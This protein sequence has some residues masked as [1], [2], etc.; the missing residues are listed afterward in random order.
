MRAGH[1]DVRYS[2]NKHNGAYNSA[3]KAAHHAAH[4]AAVSGNGPAGNGASG[5]ATHGAG[6]LRH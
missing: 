3:Y 6:R 1:D 5:N 4:H 2:G